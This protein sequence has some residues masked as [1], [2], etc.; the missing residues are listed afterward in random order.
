[1]TS[2]RRSKTHKFSG[3]IRYRLQ[4]GTRNSSST[5]PSIVLLMSGEVTIN[6]MLFIDRINLED[7]LVEFK[8]ELLVDSVTSYGEP[9]FSFDI[10]ISS[11]RTGNRRNNVADGTASAALTIQGDTARTGLADG[12]ACTMALLLRTASFP[13]S[14][15]ISYLTIRGPGTRTS[16]LSC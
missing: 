12:C 3:L 15:E 10:G 7:W 5:G 14:A 8:E 9:W 16:T 1:M 2:L 4:S 6:E 11:D 13:W